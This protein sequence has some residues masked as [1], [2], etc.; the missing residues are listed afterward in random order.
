MRNLA[1]HL[2][3]AVAVCAGPSFLHLQVVRSNSE[4]ESIPSNPDVSAAE[5]QRLRP[6]LLPDLK[7]VLARVY[8]IHQPT[9]ADLESELKAC[10]FLPLKLGA[11]GRA[12]LVEDRGPGGRN[13]VMLNVYL[14]AQGSYRRLI[15]E[16][17]F[18]PMVL[19]GDR[20]V[21]DLVFGTTMG[22]CHATRVRYRY[23]NGNYAPDACNQEYDDSAGDHSQADR[24]I[25]KEGENECPIKQCEGKI[26]LPNFPSPFA[27]DDQSRGAMLGDES[28]VVRNA[29]VP[30][31]AHASAHA[32]DNEMRFQ[33]SSDSSG[34]CPKTPP[35][36]GVWTTSDLINTRVSNDGL[37]TCLHPTPEPAEISYSGIQSGQRYASATLDCK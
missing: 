16:T 26:R 5:R 30:S 34:N 11:L 21:P 18:G 3:I 1:L 24:R 23:T 33:L 8:N 12:I 15:G 2:W 25:A 19:K 9:A 10:H 31:V 28:C 20:P 32:A 22:V 14:P 35:S 36:S 37:A 29:V 13:S 7:E 17:G 27:D 4:Q 6:V